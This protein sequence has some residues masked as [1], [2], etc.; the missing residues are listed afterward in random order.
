MF[1]YIAF[2]FL[3]ALELVMGGQA[4]AVQRTFVSTSGSDSN[5]ASN[6][7]K[8]SPCRGFTAALTVTDSGGEIIVLDSGGYGPVTIDKSVSIIAPRGVYAGISVFSGNGV[9][10][11][12]AGV[13]VVLR[14]LTINRLGGDNGISMSAGASLS[15]D[16][17]VV[18][19]FAGTWMAGLLVETPATV[20]ITRSLFEGNYH[21][22]W[23]RGGATARMTDSWFLR[24]QAHGVY[25]HSNATGTSQASAERTV[26][27]GN[28]AA[29][30]DAYATAG[31]VVLA[32]SNSMTTENGSYGLEVQSAGTGTAEANLTNTLVSHNTNIGVYAYGS[33]TRLLISGNTIIRNDDYGLYQAGSA[34]F[35]SAGNNSVRENA[36]GA[37][38]GTITALPML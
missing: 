13:H 32:V 35:L 29:G 27:S 30:F 5:T 24:N 17:C 11:A 26:S 19:N 33:A 2:M 6:C 8:A 20:S 37:S 16:N 23:I 9:T 28:G 31:S 34:T 3:L 36:L 38:S 25:V 18:S 4:L 1:H 12:T 22:A 21:G 7:A 10:I 15:V 14:G